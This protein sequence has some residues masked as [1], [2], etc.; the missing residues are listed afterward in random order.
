MPKNPLVK[1][2]ESAVRA[3]D[4][5]GGLFARMGT[6]AHPR[7]FL[8]V[9]YRNAE[10]AMKTVLTETDPLMGARD[11]MGQ[12]KTT[13]ERETRALFLE[14]QSLGMEEAARQL[15]LYGVETRPSPVLP[16]GLS[17]QSNAAVNAVTSTLDAQEAQILAM[18]LADM[19]DGQIIGDDNHDGVLSAS[20]L[21]TA[22]AYWAAVLFGDAFNGGTSGYADDFKKIA[23]A[24]LDGRTT[25]CCLEVHGQIQ[26]FDAPF[27]LTGTPRFADYMD[28][29]PFH[30][31]CRTA[32]ALYLASFDIG[33]TD[34]MRASADWFLSERAAGRSP[35]RDPANAF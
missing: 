7:G 8:P 18:I 22:I 30:W 12:L 15:S 24:A 1:S 10:R 34:Q 3:N 2:I 11:V 29:P 20:E 26:P 6:S 9:A 17:E 21:A 33:I 19:Q 32:T 27:H 16:M 23:V 14:A 5:V 35:D 25:R 31:Y 28:A 4:T 13:V